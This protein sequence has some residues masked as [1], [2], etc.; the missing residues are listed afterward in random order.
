MSDST[1]EDTGLKAGHATDF[2]E[3]PRSGQKLTIQS[4]DRAL[5][6]LEAL[7]A[8]SGRLALADIAARTGLKASTCHHL[9]STILRRGYVS[10]DRDTRRYS[11]GSKIF[12]LSEARAGQIDLLGLAM[13][14]LARLN[15]I[16]GEAI[17]LCVME[18]LNLV[19]LGK[20][21]S[22]YAVKVDSTVSKSNAAH[23]T[24]TG[25]AILAWLPESEVDEILVAK[26]M[27]RFTD[28]TIVSRDLLVEE[29]RKVRRHG[30]AEDV[31]EFE[32]GVVCIGAPVRGSKGTVLGSISLSMPTMRVS[33]ESL[34]RTRAL[35][36]EAAADMAMEIGPV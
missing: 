5:D 16:T 11:L 25:K 19:T 35:V 31:E 3:T 27:E 1:K 26:G 10:Q 36:M 9:V 30:Y 8:S 22:R 23:A 7:A 14:Y 29:L 33:E 34:Q 15:E 17:H 21:G 13:P 2:G 20:L 4:V 6:I 18:G 12:E 24:A 28:R 32:P